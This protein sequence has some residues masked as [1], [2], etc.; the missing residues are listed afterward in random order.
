VSVAL[1]TDP[2]V[3]ILFAIG[4]TVALVPEGLLPSVTMSL[5]IGAKH[6]ATENALVRQLESVETLG[7]TTF[8]CTDK[9]GTLTQN[10]MA[11]VEA[12]TPTDARIKGDGYEPTGLVEADDDTQSVLREMGTVVARC[13]TGDI[14]R[15][16]GTWVAH[17]EP[18]EAALVAFARRLDVD[19]REQTRTN[20]EIR[21]FPFDPRRRRTSVLTQDRLL[22]MGAPE[23]VLARADHG[24]EDASIAVSEMAERGLRVLAVATR[25]ADEVSVEADIES[26]ESNLEL[27]DWSALRI[28][29]DRGSGS[30]LREQKPRRS[31]QR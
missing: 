24:E 18:M 1:G 11:V 30:C 29:R 12:W 9:T 6:L 4:V 19:I 17:G 23:A 16:D 21:R 22:V 27:P 2:G 25:P 31:E 28:H 13:S 20:P 7:S 10:R 15:R 26:I 14:E 5:A 8:I 3:G